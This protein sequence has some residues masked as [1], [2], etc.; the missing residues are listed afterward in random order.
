MPL[1]VYRRQVFSIFNEFFRT[2]TL[3]LRYAFGLGDR[4]YDIVEIP[5][6][7]QTYDWSIWIADENSN[8]SFVDAVRAYCQSRN[9]PFV[10]TPEGGVTIWRQRMLEAIENQS[11]FTLLC[12]PINLVVFENA[13]GNPL[14]QFLLPIIDILGELNRTKQAWV[15]TCAQMA[16]FYRQVT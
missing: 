6:D 8:R 11:V 16:Q 15:C 10:R 5:L 3:P 12:H 1:A 2:D 13:W 9:I 14:E 4:I 7:S